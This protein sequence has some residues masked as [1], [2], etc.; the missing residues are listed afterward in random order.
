MLNTYAKKLNSGVALNQD[1]LEWYSETGIKNTTGAD[2]YVLKADGTIDIVSSKILGYGYGD[3]FRGITID[4]RYVNEYDLMKSDT[5]EIG[6]QCTATYPVERFRYLDKK[7]NW[8]YT[9]VYVKEINCV[10]SL[11]LDARE[12]ENH[13]PALN[14]S[15]FTTTGMTFKANCHNPDIHEFYWWAG[16]NDVMVLPVEHDTDH[17]EFISCDYQSPDPKLGSF[18]L[19]HDDKDG[20]DTIFEDLV[21]VEQRDMYYGTDLKAVY[22]KMAELRN[23]R[24]ID[25]AANDA[26]LLKQLA[27][28]EVLLSQKDQEIATLKKEKELSE[29]AAAVYRS[30][31]EGR[32]KA[33]DLNAKV[34]LRELDLADKREA[35]EDNEKEREAN[36]LKRTEDRIAR[37]EDRQ[38]EAELFQRK[39]QQDQVQARANELASQASMFKSA[40]VILPIVATAVVYWAK[41]TAV[42]S[43]A[44]ATAS[45]GPIG[46]AV[47]AAIALAVYAGCKLMGVDV[48]G[49]VRNAWDSITDWVG[50]IYHKVVSVASFVYSGVISGALGITKNF[51]LNVVDKTCNICKSIG[52][53]LGGIAK[54]VMVETAGVLRKVCSIAQET[55]SAIW[56]GT[57]WTAS[58]CWNGIKTVS[59]K[60]W[61]ITKSTVSGVWDKLCSG[62]DYV[63]DKARAAWNTITGWF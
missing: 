60:A 58:A 21:Y 18:R 42:T 12:M 29:K 62:A 27:D 34:K 14:G 8:V 50:A 43:I 44:G 9:P 19:K 24:S 55:G 47:A 30:E 38:Y 7:G 22:K 48:N 5:S 61:D 3:F 40:A 11:K 45:S 32:F 59:A 20:S 23:S 36:D 51:V 15:R 2:V 57:K 25:V 6:K 16:G 39:L 33:E 28:A 31:E 37:M 17:P 13:H 53:N 35:R 1:L 63:S 56:R 26:E 4:F 49:A 54:S 52:A 10:I 41:T 46:L